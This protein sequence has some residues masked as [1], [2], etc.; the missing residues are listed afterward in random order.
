MTVV[1]GPRMLAPLCLDQIQLTAERQ[2]RR[3]AGLGQIKPKS[4]EHHT[5]GL[6]VRQTDIAPANRHVALI[7]GHALIRLVG[8]WK[9]TRH[10]RPLIRVQHLSA[11]CT[12]PIIWFDCASRH[13]SSSYWHSSYFYWGDSLFMA[14]LNAPLFFFRFNLN[15]EESFSRRIPFYLNLA[16][17]TLSLRKK[18]QTA[19]FASPS[20][21]GAL[22]QA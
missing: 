15:F 3:Q 22:T 7:V 8:S 21:G 13:F 14:L 20:T 2:R 9:R 16:F 1:P 5:T 6:K 19:S 17:A 11:V 10:H 4:P 18:F 12:G